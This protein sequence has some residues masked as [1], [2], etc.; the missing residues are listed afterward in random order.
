MRAAAGEG[1]AAAY[2]LLLRAQPA[3]ADAMATALRAVRAERS[4]RKEPDSLRIR[5]GLTDPD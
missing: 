3:D 2:R 1:E 4:A 5:V